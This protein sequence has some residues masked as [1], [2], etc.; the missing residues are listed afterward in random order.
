MADAGGEGG[1]PDGQGRARP[2]FLTLEAKAALVVW[3][4]VT[5]VLV[6]VYVIVL[7]LL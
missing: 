3:T 2:T 6:V 7:L 1:E 5:L 4:A